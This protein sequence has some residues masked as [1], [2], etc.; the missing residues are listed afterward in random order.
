LRRSDHL[1]T[2]IVNVALPTLMRELHA[3]TVP[4]E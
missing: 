4:L 1:D 2:T 3:S